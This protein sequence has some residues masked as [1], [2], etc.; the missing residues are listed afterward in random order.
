MINFMLV[1]MTS[2]I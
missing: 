2:M 1:H